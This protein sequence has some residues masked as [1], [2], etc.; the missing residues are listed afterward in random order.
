MIGNLVARPDGGVDADLYVRLHTSMP[1]EEAQDLA[2]IMDVGNSW[3]DAYQA[4]GELAA[5]RE[6]QA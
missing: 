4:N 6:S 2:E 3:R 5:A 1:L